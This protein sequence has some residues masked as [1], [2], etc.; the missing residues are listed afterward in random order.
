MTATRRRRRLTLLAGL[1]GAAA[2]L[3]GRAAAQGVLDLVSE[4]SSPNLDDHDDLHEAAAGAD[5]GVTVRFLGVSTL[6]IED[7][8][9]S[10]MIDGFFTRPGFLTLRLGRVRSDAETVRTSLARAGAT[11]LDAVFVAHSHVDHALDSA[12]VAAQTGAT[13]WGSTSTR[14]IAEAANFD[15][16]RYRLVEVGRAERF[17]DFTVTAVAAEHS[18]GDLAPGEID[19]PLPDP[20]RALD[21][22][23]GDCYSFLVAHP[24]GTLL[25]HPS[26]NYVRGAYDLHRADTVYLGV[27]TLGRQTPEF[28]ETYWDEVVARVGAHRV[29]PIHWDNFTRGL[30]RPLKPFPRRFDDLDVTLDFLRQRCHAD[31]ID[32]R[33]PRVWQRADP[34]DQGAPDGLPS[35]R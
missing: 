18:P 7:A 11:R 17:G 26:A 14:R 3:Q 34:F 29:V 23:T 12:T 5:A 20:A 6:L 30:D 2:A 1:L 31:A 32:L 19:A 8:T 16:D 28:H 9:T 15:P 10:L 22:K 33:L 13:L 27:G 4:L 35:H 21:L 25:V 24:T